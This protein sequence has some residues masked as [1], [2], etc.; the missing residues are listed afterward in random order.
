[1]NAADKNLL[2]HELSELA[3]AIGGRQLEL[4][5]GRPVIYRVAL[6]DIQTLAHALVE[7]VQAAMEAESLSHE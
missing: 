6:T 4:K 1:M 3:E 7:K 5:F 2:R